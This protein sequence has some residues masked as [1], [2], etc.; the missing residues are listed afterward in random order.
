MLEDDE[1]SQVVAKYLSHEGSQEGEAVW[2]DINTAPGST[3]AK[4]HAVR[5]RS[6]GVPASHVDIDQPIDI[7]IEFWNQILGQKL[8]PNFSLIDESGTTVFKAI[9]LPNANLNKDDSEIKPLEKG[10]YRSICSIPPNFLNDRQYFLS[11]VIANTPSPHVQASVNEVLS[12]SVNDTGAMRAPQFNGKW[13]GMI[14]T[15]FYWRTEKIG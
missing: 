9:N 12:F 6:N 13:L 11:V 14:R 4:L 7:E 3:V 10:L 15:P 1:T 2:D 8:V 5:V